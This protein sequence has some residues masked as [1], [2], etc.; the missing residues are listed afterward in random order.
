MS[1]PFPTTDDFRPLVLVVLSDGQQKHVRSIIT[2]VA[3][4]GG[5]TSEQAAER[6]PSG[7]SRAENRITWAISSLVNAGAI[8]RPIRAH[9]AINDTGRELARRFPGPFR[10]RDL[11]GLPKWDAYQAELAERKRSS[12]RSADSTLN[13]DIAAGR[14]P[15]ETAASAVEQVNDEVASDLLT[16]IREESW[17][18]FEVAVLK[19]LTAMGYGGADGAAATTSSSND[20]GIDGIIKQDA[21]G[22]QNIY[23]QAKRYSSTNT[24]QRPE[25]QGFVG[26]FQVLPGVNSGVF[27][28]TSTFSEGARQYAKGVPGKIVLIDGTRLTSLMLKYRVGVQVK[29]A[30]EILEIDEDFFEH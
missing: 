4:L 11:A 5:V 30:L 15:E 1:T 12:T 8:D 29:N 3:E 24:V 22:I 19:L 6:L 25:L 7:Q 20:G 18:F 16:R 13:S 28:T 17:Q 27:I 10:D 23:V 26:A 9:Y 2:E 14:S 21:L